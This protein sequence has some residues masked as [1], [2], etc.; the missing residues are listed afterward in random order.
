ML[1]PPVPLP[2]NVISR[3]SRRPNFLRKKPAKLLFR[4][5]SGEKVTNIVHIL[6]IEGIVTVRRVCATI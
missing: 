6:W 4:K 2:P 1:A 3:I 5:S